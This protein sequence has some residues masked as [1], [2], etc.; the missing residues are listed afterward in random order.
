MNPAGRHRR[1][2]TRTVTGSVLLFKNPPVAMGRV[3][4]HGGR[5]GGA[6][7]RLAS[8]SGNKGGGDRRR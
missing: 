5:V 4:G 8:A 2:L 7:W 1:A 3:A 6:I